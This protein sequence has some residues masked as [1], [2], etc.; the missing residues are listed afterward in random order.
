MKKPNVFIV[1]AP[2]SGTSSMLHYLR[3][4]PDIFMAWGE[5]HFFGSDIAYNP[6]P[7]SLKDYLALFEESR[8]ERHIG[9]KSSWYLLSKRAAGEIRAFNPDAGIIIQIR[10]PVDLIHSLHHHFAFHIG[11]EPLK[12]FSRALEMEETRKAGKAIPSKARFPEH[13]FY[14]EVPR[15]REQIERFVKHFGWSRIHVVV[16]DDLVNDTEREYRRVLE[17]LGTDSGFTPDFS[18]RNPARTYRLGFLNALKN[19]ERVRSVAG[20][21]IPRSLKIRLGDRIE[22]VNAV[23]RKN[24]MDEALRDKLNA[25]FSEEVSKTSE[26]LGRDLTHWCKPRAK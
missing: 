16:F 12:N 8:A 24:P 10:N 21:L 20:K 7:L 22:D 3:Q 11:R 23:F 26:L 4:H 18:P 15:F 19:S 14:T 5:P 1:G 9:E 25:L 6:A 17:F 13:Y 2:R